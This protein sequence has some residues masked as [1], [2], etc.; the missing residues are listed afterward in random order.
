MAEAFL[1]LSRE[2]RIEALGVATTLSG[3]SPHILEKDVWVVWMRIPMMP[4]CHSEIMPPSI[5]G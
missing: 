1:R 5:P 3:R 2:D 4:P